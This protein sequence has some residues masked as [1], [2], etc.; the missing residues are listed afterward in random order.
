MTSAPDRPATTG[1]PLSTRDDG[2]TGELNEPIPS[3]ISD[4]P[5]IPS[6]QAPSSMGLT[7]APMGSAAGCWESAPPA[8]ASSSPHSSG[9]AAG[10]LSSPKIFA[11]APHPYSPPTTSGTFEGMGRFASRR[12]FTPGALLPF[13]LPSLDHFDGAVERISMSALQTEGLQ[14]ATTRR[15][16]VAYRSFRRYLRSTPAPDRFLA[17]DVRIQRVILEGWIAW[18]RDSGRARNAIATYWRGL[19]AI[20][21][22][23]GEIDGLVNPCWLVPSPPRENLPQP[24]YLTRERTEALFRYVQ[25]APWRSPL[26]RWRNTCLFGLLSL[27]GLRRQETLNLL[28]DDVR[29]DEGTLRIRHGKGRNGGRDRTAYMTPQLRQVIECYLSERRHAGRSHPEFLTALYQ[30]KGLGVMAVRRLFERT[31][32]DLGTRLTPHMLRHTYATLL[33]QS[34]VPDRVAM[35]LLGHRS[36]AMLQRYSHVVDGEH[37][38]EAA[39]LALRIDLDT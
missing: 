6:V 35:D 33:R 18:L 14:P 19:S 24:S 29:P 22:R 31:S 11:P 39:R 3:L 38:Q 26:E 34:G 1:Q 9:S 13:H 20:F 28:M 21:H 27:A 7:G 36:L 37:L 17:G 8:L 25:N 4:H 5:P 10:D 15:W 16:L 23:I 12:G 2:V 32:R 30:N